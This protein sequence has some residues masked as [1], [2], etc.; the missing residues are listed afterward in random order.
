MMARLRGPIRKCAGFWIIAVAA[1]GGGDG[2]AQ[3]SG[4]API[5]SPSA[6]AAAAASATG[7]T[8]GS[9]TSGI[10][11]TST[12]DEDLRQILA[13]ASVDDAL[14]AKF[15]SGK[16]ADDAERRPTL[17]VLAALRGFT[18]TDLDRFAH[19]ARGKADLAAP[20]ARGRIWQLRG[21]LKSLVAEAISEEEFSRLYPAE[22][23]TPPP[24]DPRRSVYRGS[25]TLDGG[26]TAQFVSLTAPQGLR[27]K[28]RPE[29]R[30][31]LAGLYVKDTAP[32]GAAPLLLARR[33]AWYDDGPLGKLD[34]DVGLFDDVR[35]HSS[36][37]KV[38]RECFYQL[39]T[40]L[41]R[42]DLATL[43]DATNADYSVEPLFND[44]DSIRGKLI[45]LEGRA[46]RAVEVRVAD[47]DIRRRFGIDRYYEIALFTR[48]SQNNP[49][50][51]DVV[52]LPA[53]FPLGDDIN[54]FVRIPGVFLTGFTY[55]RDATIEE[56]QKG[57]KPPMQKAPLLIGKSPIRVDYR[58]PDESFSWWIGGAI[59]L[60]AA[61][62]GWS[63]WR[64]LTSG[65]KA[66]RMRDDVS[67]AR[68]AGT[69]NSL[70]GEYSSKPDFSNLRDVDK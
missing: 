26:E 47:V 39:L 54:E 66:R 21:K 64:M 56:R 46:R 36:D 30:I 6:T 70:P 67:A 35:E 27:D 63:A 15:V 60:G 32:D 7:A 14:L 43:A 3:P 53:G 44:P 51:F 20:A 50:L 5:S 11:A 45:A 59:V 13:A 24:A 38:E 69:L 61:L 62:V 4:A 19:P 2:R 12:A 41:R 1:L 48:D 42:G 22:E 34:M 52:D 57:L 29:T 33:I 65:S 55:H 18:P 28:P 40:A 37:L 49:L 8:S 31:G 17:T 23:G 25:I 16:P 9:A 58:A 68:T 10:T